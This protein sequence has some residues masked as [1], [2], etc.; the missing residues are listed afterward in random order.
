MVSYP[1]SKVRYK[2][3]AWNG[4]SFKPFQSN[5]EEDDFEFNN[6]NYHIMNL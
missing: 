6:E 1:P 5:K 3:D 2:I 4:P